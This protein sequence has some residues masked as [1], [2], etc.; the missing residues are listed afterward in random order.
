MKKENLPKKYVEQN[1]KNA[2]IYE[3]LMSFKLNVQR[4]KFIFQYSMPYKNSFIICDFYV[5]KYNLIIEVDGMY[6]DEILQ[7]HKDIE[8]DK[9]LI[10]NGY[11]VL[12]MF[13]NEIDTFDTSSIKNYVVKPVIKKAVKVN[14][15]LEQKLNDKKKMNPKDY[16]K[17]YCK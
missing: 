11:N 2:T 6:H 9:F 17:K 5:P 16:K 8:R 15:T 10:E 7:A 3:K 1:R 12:R 4:I 13:N 14:Y